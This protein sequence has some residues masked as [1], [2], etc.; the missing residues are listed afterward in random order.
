LTTEVAPLQ[1]AWSSSYLAD[2]LFLEI[3]EHGPMVDDTNDL[4]P[5]TDLPVAKINKYYLE[6][7][8]YASSDNCSFLYR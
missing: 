3:C 4:L 2:Q 6:A 5:L 7:A 8:K 1:E